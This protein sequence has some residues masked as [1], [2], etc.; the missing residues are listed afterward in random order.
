[1]LRLPPRSTLTCTLFPYAT[2]VRSVEARRHEKLNESV[3]AHCCG[4][5]RCEFSRAFQE[6]HG[7]T[8]RQYLQSLRMRRAVDMLVRTDAPITEIAFCVGFHDPSH[9]ANQF[10]HHTDRKSTRLNSSH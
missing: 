4:W 10:R 2:L 1:M 8:F 6:E 7:V 5:S 9:F 3:V